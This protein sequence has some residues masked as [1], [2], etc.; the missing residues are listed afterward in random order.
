MGC[1]GNRFRRT[2]VCL[3]LKRRSLKV[4]FLS[5]FL[6]TALT[7]ITARSYASKHITS[8]IITK[9]QTG[10]D[11]SEAVTM[12]KETHHSQREIA[13]KVTHKLR[14]APSRAIR[15]V[16][17]LTSNHLRNNSQH[18]EHSNR[19]PQ[20]RFTAAQDNDHSQSPTS[21]LRSVPTSGYMMVVSYV[22][23]L[24]SA[25][26]DMY[27]LLHLAM[28]WNMKLVE[29][30]LLGSYF[31]IPVPKATGTLVRFRDI[32]N[33]TV[34]N[35]Q[36]R[37]CTHSKYP[38]IASYEEFAA[39]SYAGVW[40][41]DIMRVG[42]PECSVIFQGR[43]DDK[44]IENAIHELSTKVSN[45]TLNHTIHISKRICIDARKEINFEKL[46]Y[47]LGIPIPKPG[48][49]DRGSNDKEKSSHT[50]T[51][52]Q[53]GIVFRHWTGIRNEPNKF[54]YH[55]PEFHIPLCPQI[56]TLEH[57]RTVKITAQLLFAHLKLT[58]PLLGIHIRLE[59]L[60]T[61]LDVQKPG[62]MKECVGKLM[63]TV[64]ALKE[65]Y[66]LKSGQ[67]LAARDYGALGSQ[68]CRQK[69]CYRIATELQIDAR[70]TDLGVRLADYNPAVLKIPNH[71]GLASTVEKELISTSDYLLTV[72]WGSFQRSVRDRIL[73]RH[74]EGGI[75][76]VYSLCSREG[77]KLS[78]LIY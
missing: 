77:D 61:H 46:L 5:L 17:S 38:L 12:E 39:Q 63:S 47:S 21:Q 30:F 68:T 60:I 31:G 4:F 29:P 53:V 19:Q 45:G 71:S 76:R 49:S 41:M 11:S 35:E 54:Y 25:V 9:K 74:P 48:I 58:R 18:N 7:V 43:K 13:N 75:E 34:V 62:T 40:Q 15:P 1:L 66:N 22:E 28:R 59:K 51:R 36:L 64:K 56:H 23:Q 6:G 67:V 2:L 73:K 78:N 70:L 52:E 3:G 69:Q 37:E 8:E 72:G 44:L 26:W 50:R 27:Q 32:Y 57:S 20:L 42:V 14:H 33:M 16:P 10:I 55:D 65:K 24:E